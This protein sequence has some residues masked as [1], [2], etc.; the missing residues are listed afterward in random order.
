MCLVFTITLAEVEEMNYVRRTVNNSSSSN[1]GN[2][3]ICEIG[4]NRK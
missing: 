4:K 2:I 3:E 1:N